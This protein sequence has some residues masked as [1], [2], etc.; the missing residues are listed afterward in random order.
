MNQ[1]HLEKSSFF[2]SVPPFFWN[3]L[4]HSQIIKS[5]SDSTWSSTLQLHAKLK[6]IAN[7]LSGEI[8]TKIYLNGLIVCH[9]K[10]N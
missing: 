8:E 4:G 2:N 9:G 3:E 1:C 6:E 7:I 5:V 10:C